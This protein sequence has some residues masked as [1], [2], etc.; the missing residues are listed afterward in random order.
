[1]ALTKKAELYK[2]VI[3]LCIKLDLYYQF[4]HYRY[5]T[6]NYWQLQYKIIKCKLI[7]KH[8]IIKK[9]LYPLPH[10]IELEIYK[11]L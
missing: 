2:N 9:L 6:T 10:D 7:N 11:Y 1:M 4:Q 3:S 8:L 5:T